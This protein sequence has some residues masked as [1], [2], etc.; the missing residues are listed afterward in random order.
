MAISVERI[1]ADI[2][3]IARFTATPGR[4][5][6]RPTFSAAWAGARDYV[7]EQAILAGCV[8]RTDAAGN[9]HARP[10]DLGWQERAWLCG[11]HI[12]SVPHGGDY[13]GVAGVVTGLELLRSAA[14]DKTKSAIEM[15]IFAEEEGPTFGLGMLGSRGWTGELSAA[16]L[17]AL[18]NAAGETYLEAGKPFGVD[19][20]TLRDDRL[21]PGGYLGF[22]ELHIE[23]GPGMW[24]RDQ[25]FAIVNAIAGRRQYQVTIEGEANHA[26]ATSM[27]DR[28]DALVGAA[29]AI[30]G[31]ELLA[32]EFGHGT[33]ITVGRLENHPNAVNVVPDNVT[34]TIDFR[35]GDDAVLNRWAELRGLI[36]EVCTRRDLK[37]QFTLSEEIPARQMNGHLIQRLKTAAARCGIGEAPITV[38]GALHDSAVIAPY[39]PSAMVFVPSR[40]GISHNP[41]EFSR[42]EDIAL[43]AG[44]IEQVMRTP[45]IGRVN[46]M[47]RAEF[48]THFGGVFEH[49]PWIAERAWDQ[50]PF[51]SV[52]DL[53][54]KMVNIVRAATPEERLALIRAHPDLVGRLARQGGLTAD[55]TAE[56]QAAGLRTLTADDVVAFDLNNAKYQAKF[57]FPFVIC[58][59]ENKK[60]AILAAFPVR[61]A[62]TRD[63]EITTAI[64]EIAKIARLRLSDSVME[65]L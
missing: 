1:Q 2:E 38:S 56:Q 25:R 8:I 54:E 11:S 64:A 7:I 53:H 13:D 60:D 19:G 40:G 27:L 35:C 9:V 62:N 22:I 5:A 3:A 31:L 20:R 21:D 12:D 57:G 18:T 16:E 46:E 48:V 51:D 26:G 42:V 39:L 30:I 23:Q 29:A 52:A 6:S 45:T 61:L 17:A 59:R 55:S 47:D 63:N 15:I 28:R 43:A 34:F 33:V 37:W 32:G 65:P 10:A 49:S 14:E 24:M 4:G 58:A 36:E 41:A 50:R 44:V